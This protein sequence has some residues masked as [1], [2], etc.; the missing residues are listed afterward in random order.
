MGNGTRIEI[1]SEH[2]GLHLDRNIP[3]C[4]R[5]ILTDLLSHG[6][7]PASYPVFSKP[8]INL[9]GMGMGSCTLQSREEYLQRQTPGHFWMTLLNGEHVSSDIAVINGEMVWV[10]HAIG[11]SVAGGPF[12]HWA[13]DLR[14]RPALG[15]YLRQ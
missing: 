2:N 15:S 11:E 10:R 6:V 3:C 13:S 8:I 5:T 4:T 12:G 9:R 14:T 1:S 7:E